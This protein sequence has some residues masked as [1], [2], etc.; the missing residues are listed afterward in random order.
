[1]SKRK[2]SNPFNLYTMQETSGVK[3]LNVETEMQ[4]ATREFKELWKQFTKDWKALQ[5][6][7][8]ELGA[9]DTA[10]REDQA[11]WIRKHVLKDI[12]Y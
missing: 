10:A 12:S 8:D 6:K 11:A 7:W 3:Y 4:K 1:M 2:P 5:K 9:S